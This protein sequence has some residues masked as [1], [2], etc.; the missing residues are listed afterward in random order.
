VLQ[1]LLELDLS[2][3]SPLD[4]LLFLRSLQERLK[5]VSREVVEA[6]VS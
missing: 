1:E 6:P 5:G 4:A 3:T 2:R